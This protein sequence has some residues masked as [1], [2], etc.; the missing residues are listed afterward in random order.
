MKFCP[1]CGRQ[2]ED[3]VNFCPACGTALTSPNQTE[4]VVNGAKASHKKQKSSTPFVVILV[5]VI[6]VLLAVI[7]LLVGLI[8]KFT[9]KND[10]ATIVDAESIEASETVM[11]DETVALTT[12]STTPTIVAEGQVKSYYHENDV[13]GYSKIE[14]RDGKVYLTFNLLEGICVGVADYTFDGNTVVLGE[15]YSYSFLFDGETTYSDD[16]NKTLIMTKGAILIYVDNGFSPQDF[17]LQWVLQGWNVP[18]D[19]LNGSRFYAAN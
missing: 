19:Y 15:V 5:A 1:Y 2:N 18:H 4:A 17:D 10:E 11:V 12:E 13:S 16:S 6:G 14:F 8:G 3:N 9:L 7:I